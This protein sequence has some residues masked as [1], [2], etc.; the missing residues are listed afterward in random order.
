MEGDHHHEDKNEA[1]ETQCSL[2]GQGGLGGGHWHQ[3]GHPDCPRALAASCLGEP[4]KGGGR[5]RLPE[6]FGTES[7]ADDD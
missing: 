7:E 1:E 4:V 3:D 2:Q 6:L 5:Q